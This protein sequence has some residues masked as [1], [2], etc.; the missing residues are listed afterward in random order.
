MGTILLGN[1]PL[2]VVHIDAKSFPSLY[3]YVDFRE[4]RFVYQDTTRRYEFS[5]TAPEGN[6]VEIWHGVINPAVGRSWKGKEDIQKIKE[7]LDK[8]HDF[9]T[10]KGKFTPS[11]LPP[12]VFYYDGYNESAALD[13]RALY[14]YVLSIKNMENFAYKRFS[15]YLLS[16]INSVLKAYDEKN[17]SDQ[18]ATLVSL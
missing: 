18:N 12:R 11:S 13:F 17:N 14:Q 2:P 10:G 3:P 15:K 5:R 16:D 4:K 7:F 8:T 6:D 9:Y 1:V